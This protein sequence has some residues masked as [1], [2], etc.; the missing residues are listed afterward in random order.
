MIYCVVSNGFLRKRDKIEFYDNCT[1]KLRNRNYQLN[2]ELYLNIMKLLP[3]GL[4]EH[5]QKYYS[6][7]E[8]EQKKG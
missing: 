7:F 4:R 1:I 5:W 2:E 6:C 8:S 3:L